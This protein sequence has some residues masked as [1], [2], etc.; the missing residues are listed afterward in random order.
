MMT[1][2]V[3]GIGAKLTLLEDLLLR[4]KMQITF[5]EVLAENSLKKSK[6]SCFPAES[7]TA[8]RAITSN[9]SKISMDNRHWSSRP[10]GASVEPLINSSGGFPAGKF[11][12]KPE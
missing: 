3:S 11:A 4:K 8:R 10:Y 1:G 6:I 12:N 7:S 9:C 2:S 5:G